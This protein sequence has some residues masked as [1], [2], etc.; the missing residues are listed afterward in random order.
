[1]VPLL[2][3]LLLAVDNGELTTV[4]GVVAVAAWRQRQQ[5]QGQW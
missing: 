5:Q 2:L 3:P 4:V 1:V